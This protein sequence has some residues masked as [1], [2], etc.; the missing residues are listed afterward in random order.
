MSM[1]RISFYDD[2]RGVFRVRQPGEHSGDSK[3][4]EFAGAGGCS[5]VGK[6]CSGIHGEAGRSEPPAVKPSPTVRTDSNAGAG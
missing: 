4:C 6:S 1:Q 2:S 5:F 3:V